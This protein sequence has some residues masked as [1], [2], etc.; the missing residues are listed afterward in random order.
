[1]VGDVAARHGQV[2]LI[3]AEPLGKVEEEGG[4][5]LNRALAA[6]QQHVVL[7]PLQRAHHR[8]HDLTGEGAVLAREALQAA[9]AIGDHRGFPHGLG[10]EAV[11]VARLDAED[12]AG[13]VKSIDLAAAVGEELR[14]AD[15]ARHDLVE[16]GRPVAFQE[17]LLVLRE[18]AGG[19]ERL[20]L[21]RTPHR[22]DIAADRGS[23]EGGVGKGGL[24]RRPRHLGG[25]DGL[26]GNR[27]QQQ[28]KFR[29]FA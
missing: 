25:G 3:V 22:L 2:Q 15:G 21:G 7:R 13:Q 5:L 28:R 11:L 19:A 20:R 23:V 9:A 18:D 29:C 14:G 26:R 10:R 27:L 6:E 12:V 24:H 4:D 1:M 16:G 17:Q 8:I